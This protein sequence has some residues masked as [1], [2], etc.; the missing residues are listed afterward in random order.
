MTALATKDE[1]AAFAAAHRLPLEALHVVCA[2]VKVGT[3]VYALPRPARHH[4][5]LWFMNDHGVPPRPA[6]QGFLLS[7]GRFTLRKAAAG[8]ALRAGQTQV[9]QV[10]PHLYS[11]DL[12]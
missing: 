12:W 7:D 9:L 8:V 11:E 2:A 1:A 10:P 3:T 4:N 5:V 6:D